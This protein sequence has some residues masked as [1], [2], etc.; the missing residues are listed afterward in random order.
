MTKIL[1]IVKGEY[2]LFISSTE[3]DKIHSTPVNYKVIVFEDS[4]EHS[5]FGATAEEYIKKLIRYDSIEYTREMF[6][7]I[8]D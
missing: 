6:E 1:N 5:Y 2:V 4:H 3:Y 7:I 8:Y